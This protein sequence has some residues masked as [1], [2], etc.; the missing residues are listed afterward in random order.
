MKTDYQGNL[1]L[2]KDLRNIDYTP[3]TN[4]YLALSTTPISKDGT[5]IVEPSK[6]YGYSRVAIPIG[7]TSWSVPS[8]GISYNNIDIQFP[9]AT[10]SWGTIVAVA[11]FDAETGGNMRYY[12]ALP[13]AKVVQ[14]NATFMFK[15]GALK[16]VIN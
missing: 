9:E 8:Q 4:L 14:Q 2:N 5:G 15:T 7:S 13:S 16:F 12:E 11:L 1:N 3:P 6:S 10:N